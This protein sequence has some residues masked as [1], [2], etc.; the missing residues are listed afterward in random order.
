[1]LDFKE[2]VMISEASKED[3]MVKLEDYADAMR[4]LAAKIKKLNNKDDIEMMKDSYASYKKKHDTI[5]KMIA[6][7]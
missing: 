7:K 5:E 4:E 1:M 3:L 2:F 6:K